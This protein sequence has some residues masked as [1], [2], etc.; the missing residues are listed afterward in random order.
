MGASASAPA[1]LDRAKARALVGAGW[2]EETEKR[3]AEL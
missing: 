3:W 2:N 1:E